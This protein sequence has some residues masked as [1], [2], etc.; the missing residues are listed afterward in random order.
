MKSIVSLFRSFGAKITLILIL[1][2]LFSGA[3]ANFLIYKYALDNQFGQL[4][5]KL[6]TIA[7]MS[8]LE[9][10]AEALGRIPLSEDAVNTADY[11]AVADRMRLI[12]NAVPS[13]KYIYTLAKTE[14][15]GILKFIVDLE[16]KDKSD[17]PS[18]KPGEEYDAS[19]F[20]QM[21]AGFDAPASDDKMD[22]DKWG[23]FL[24]GY[25]PVRDARGNTVAIV[26]V[27]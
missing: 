4:R 23:V 12:R 20:S 9:I 18:A 11:K 27:D 21:L 19:G 1:S 3:M 16:N 26:G 14:N 10:D 22:R 8:A 13:I 7:V 24:S 6:K 25:A 5:D 15:P 17:T 2:M